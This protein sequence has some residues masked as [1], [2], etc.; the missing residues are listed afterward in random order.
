MATA[1][2]PPATAFVPLEDVPQLDILI[3]QSHDR[4]VLIFKHSTTCGTSF[5]AYDELD[6]YVRRPGSLPVYL[7]DV[8]GA[9]QVA[10]EIAA[11]F[12]IRH[13]SPQVLVLAGGQVRWHASHYRV[14]LDEVDRAVAS[15]PLPQ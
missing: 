12:G 4:P 2:T 3:A 9:R 1:S 11:R 14:S 15:L 10:R 8:H 6:E 5:Q 13:E 7:V